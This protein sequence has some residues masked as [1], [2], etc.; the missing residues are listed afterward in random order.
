MKMKDGR[1]GREVRAV[2]FDFDG[3]LIRSLEDHHRSW[4]EAFGEFGVEITWE[5]FAPLEGQ[6]L[7]AISEQLGNSHGLSIGEA[8]RAAFRKNQIYLETAH[9]RLYEGATELLEFLRSRGL[10]MALVTGAHRD[11]LDRSVDAEFR[12]YFG[13]IV[14]ADDVHRTK[15]DPEPFL[16][17]AAD[18]NV[19][20]AACLVVENAPLGLRAAR[21]AG[22]TC[23]AVTTTL[24][25]AQLGEADRIVAGLSDVL[26]MFAGRP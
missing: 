3:V 5:E 11:R 21:R 4:N 7:Y 20:A 23:V 13:S 10:P 24:P 9:P 16:R 18:L 8:R 14:T 26:A 22:M 19:P 2:L 25:A 17:A 6:S 15:P 1:W 12:R